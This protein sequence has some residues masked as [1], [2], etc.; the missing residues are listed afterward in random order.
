MRTVRLG[1]TLTQQVTDQLRD[2]IVSGELAPNTL[3]SATALG[4]QFG[5]SRTPIREAA[6]E[7]ARLG[8]VAIEPNK[9][10]RILQTSTDTLLEGFELRLV[11]E[12][13]MAR[14]AA[15]RARDR[16]VPTLVDAF[17]AFSD[18]AATG[19]VSQTLRADRDFH[20][21]ILELA[22][23]KRAAETL[24]EQ[25]NMVLETGIGTVP[26]SRTCQECFEDHRA[27]YD[28]IVTGD[29]DAAATAMR[30]HIIGT[31]RMLLRQETARRPEFGE[32]DVDA[33]L[34][35]IPV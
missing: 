9:G 30:A 23:N 7:L 19:D 1:P 32:V 33:Q 4:A 25:R 11:I 3:H 15:L 24:R 28:A 16:E 6:F 18:A 21:A 2:A 22:G 12:V 27:I 13:P 17:D 31:A 14:K 8:L 20:T 26:T 29:G 10:I 5:V 35:W 34:G